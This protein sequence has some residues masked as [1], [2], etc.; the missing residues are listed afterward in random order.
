MDKQ[1]LDQHLEDSWERPEIVYDLKQVVAEIEKNVP[2]D[3][4]KKMMYELVD[5]VLEMGERLRDI[6]MRTGTYD[7]YGTHKRKEEMLLVTSKKA[8]ARPRRDE[9]G[10]RRPTTTAGTREQGPLN[11]K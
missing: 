8:M 1:D 3:R 9:Y 6:E 2:G 4:T 7:A 11:Q 10:W 5:V